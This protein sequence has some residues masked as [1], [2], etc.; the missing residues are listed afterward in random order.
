MDI[1]PNDPQWQQAFTEAFHR[2]LINSAI[3][4]VFIIAVV[5]T[6]TVFARRNKNTAVRKRLI[7][8]RKIILY[9]TIIG[10]V[11]ATAIIIGLIRF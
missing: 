9:A 4:F 11:L 5:I 7:L 2:Y 6:L 8:T 10:W 1:S 3:F